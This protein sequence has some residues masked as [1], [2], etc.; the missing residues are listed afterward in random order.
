[1]RYDDAY[2]VTTEKR[3]SFSGVLCCFVVL[4]IPLFMAVFV[5][6]WMTL[7][8]VTHGTQMQTEYLNDANTNKHGGQ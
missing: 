7:C 3:P 8:V 5:I 1:M 4:Q 6:I 2:H